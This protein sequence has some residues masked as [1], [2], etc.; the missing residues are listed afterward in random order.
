MINKQTNSHINVL[1]FYLLGTVRKK[2]LLMRLKYKIDD[3]ISRVFSFLIK[4]ASL[5]LAEIY[6]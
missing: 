5:P 2:E 4:K 6:F 3:F 1:F